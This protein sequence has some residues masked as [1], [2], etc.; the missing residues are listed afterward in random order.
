MQDIV[1]DISIDSNI[2]GRPENQ[3]YALRLETPIGQLL[4]VCDGMGGNKGGA[5]ASE[6]ASRVIRR[7]FEQLKGTE[8]PLE[9]MNNAI[10]KANKVLFDRSKSDTALRGMGTTVAML[11]IAPGA[12]QAYS[13]HVGDSRIYQIRKGKRTF[14][15][16]DHSVVQEMV[17][18]GELKEKESRHHPDS[19]QITRALGVKETVVVEQNILHSKPWDVFLITSDGIHG[20]I[21][22]S[23]FLKKVAHGKNSASITQDLIQTC[24]ANG[25]KSK[26]GR[27]DNL[28]V[29]TA[30]LLPANPKV[31]NRANF[32]MLVTAL[33]AVIAVGG[34]YMFHGP[35]GHLNNNQTLKP[36][37]H[38]TIDRPLDPVLIERFKRLCETSHFNDKSKSYKDQIKTQLND[39]LKI[40]FSN[41]LFEPAKV[42]YTVEE[43]NKT[44]TILKVIESNL[45]KKQ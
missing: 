3:D 31:F 23:D 21:D 11:L 40:D 13:S 25:Q 42:G 27:H 6:L 28:T 12:Y 24:Y 14:K 44:E 18:R 5:V 9:T 30:V 26:A 38:D 34:W 1:L 29:V 7:E 41:C 36:N 8:N 22:E 32:T 35:G 39:Y 20:E 10:Q 15:S 19:N 43:R 33:V 2:G 37:N 16:K 17:D 4:L 45:T